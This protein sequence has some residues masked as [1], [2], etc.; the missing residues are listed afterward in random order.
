MSSTS[1]RT[2]RVR[3]RMSRAPLVYQ[4][5]FSRRG[6]ARRGAGRKPKGPKP[7]VSH[8]TRPKLASRFPVLV[9]LKLDAGLPSLR[10]TRERDALRRILATPRE[11]H[12][13]RVVHYSIQSNHVH[14]L[15]EAS[16]ERALSRGMQSLAVRVAQALNGLWRRIGRVFF[17]RYHSR[18]LRTPRE[19]RNALGYVLNNARR[20]GIHFAGVDPCSSGAAFDGWMQRVDGHVESCVV[21][22]ARTWLLAIGWR[23]HGRIRVDEVP[24]RE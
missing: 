6:G 10:R 17:D 16:H 20:H 1:S 3:R 9:T 15:V 11:R 13:M 18:I 7:L 24:G 14:A 21:A 23:G 19:V 2:E 22:R 5:T 8:A 4:L 12:G